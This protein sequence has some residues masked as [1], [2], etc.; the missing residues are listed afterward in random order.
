MRRSDSA[1]SRYCQTTEYRRYR[2]IDQTTFDVIST[3]RPGE[4]RVLYC[5]KTLIFQTLI[6]PVNCNILISGLPNR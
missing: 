5:N 3:K 2:Y 6:I 1:Q 4:I